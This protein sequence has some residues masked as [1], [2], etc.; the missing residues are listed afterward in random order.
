MMCS[1]SLRHP[2]LHRG[3]Y[4][5]DVSVLFQKRRLK[6]SRL[7]MMKSKGQRDSSEMNSQGSQA[8]LLVIAANSY[9][10]IPSHIHHLH[11]DDH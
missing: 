7:K 6:M 1:D 4:D 2:P 9:I 5:E 11:T 10:S 3:F 8:T